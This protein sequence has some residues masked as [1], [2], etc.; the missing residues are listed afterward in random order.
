MTGEDQ[1]ILIPS[2]VKLSSTLVLSY[3]SMLITMLRLL[4]IGRVVSN[5]LERGF[6]VDRN[7]HS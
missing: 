7:V 3:S 6:I 1:N 2:M 4:S 5:Q